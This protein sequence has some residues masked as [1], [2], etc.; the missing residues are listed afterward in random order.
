MPQILLHLLLHPLILSILV[1]LVFVKLLTSPLF[2][3]HTFILNLTNIFI[4]QILV[5]SVFDLTNS[6]SKQ[7]LHFAYLAPFGAYFVVHLEDERVFFGGPL[8]AND[9][10]VNDVVPTL[11][12]LTAKAT[13]EIP[14]YYNPVLGAIVFNLLPEYP[15]FFLGPLCA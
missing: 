1:F 12:T 10:R 2:I 14:S 13:W 7:W 5:E 6:S 11:T 3:C 8:A 4:F 15:V 9:R